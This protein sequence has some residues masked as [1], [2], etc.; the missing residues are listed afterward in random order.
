MGVANVVDKYDGA[1]ASERGG[2]ELAVAVEVRSVNNRF[3]KV[4]TNSDLPV[5]IQANVEDLLRKRITRGTVNARVRM[6]KTRD[7]EAYRINFAAIDSYRSQLSN[8]SLPAADISL[9][10]MLNLPGVI[11]ETN[12]DWNSDEV[13]PVVEQAVLAA[14]E[15][16]NEM[17]ASEGASMA[18]SLQE[19]LTILDGCVSAIETLAPKTVE[20]F[21]TR[22]TDRINSLLE[23]YDIRVQS[24]DVIREIGIFAERADIA[25]EIV[26]LKSHLELFQKTMKESVSNGRKLDFVVQEMLRETNTIGSKCSDSSIAA[27]V[28]DMKTAIERMR[29]MVQNVE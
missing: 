9:E 28:V 3:F 12:D 14:V 26:R 7:A 16:L 29:E 15:N 17:R 2:G 23:K 21:S 1:R 8:Q 5:D 18:G 25:E 20:N 13:W 19:N 4:I 24:S 10:A 11:D 27:V 6:S 22:L